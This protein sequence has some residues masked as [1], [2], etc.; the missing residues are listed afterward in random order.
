M[1]SSKAPAAIAPYSRWSSSRR[2]PGMPRTPIARPVRAPGR[3]RPDPARPGRRLD[4]HPVDEVGQ[5]AHPVDV[6]AVVDDDADAADVEQVE[7]TGRLEERRRE[8]PQALADV[9]EVRAGGPRR[10]RRGQGVRHVHPGPPA[11][12]RRDEVRVQDRHRPR[13]EAED[14]QLA[15]GRGLERERGAAATRVPVD[16]VEAVLAL[17]RGHAEQHDPARAVAAHPVDVVVVGVQHGRPRAR[18]GLDDDALD[19]GQLA[20]RVDA[21]QTEVVAGDVGHDGHVVAVVA[22]PLAQDPAARDLEHGRVDSRVLEDHLGRLRPGHV[23][24]LDEPAVDDDAVGRGHPDPP[25][26]QLQDVGDHPDGRRLP[27]RAGH[28][29]DRDPRAGARREQRIDDRPGDV[30][31]LAL[32]RVGVH[33]EAGRGVDLDDRAAGLADRAT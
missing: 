11:E 4:H 21:A 15:L 28:G 7:P 3:R 26:H 22:E 18:H 1:I 8:R 5:L 6:V 29:D 16:P 2:S 23:A 24:L 33:P 25:A 12:R 31:R 10:G 32:G 9:V 19:V 13:P 14:D 20:D 17:R 27:V 30:L